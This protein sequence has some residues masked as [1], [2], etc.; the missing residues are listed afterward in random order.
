MKL[1]WF[2][3]DNGERVLQEWD[4]HNYKWEDVPEFKMPEK[5]VTITEKELDDAWNA[6]RDILREK[7]KNGT[8][9]ENLQ[10]IISR[11]LGF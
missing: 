11:L 9:N 7:A 4:V 1:R 3:K 8:F 5:T 10:M 6:A 2:I